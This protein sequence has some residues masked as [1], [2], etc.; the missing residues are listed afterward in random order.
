M[1]KG[2]RVREVWRGQTAI[3]AVTGEVD[4]LTAPSME[5]AVMDCL[6][7]TPAALIIDLLRTEFLSSAGIG[8]LIGAQKEADEAGIGFSVVADSPGTSRPLTL[9]N[10]DEILNLQP[11]VDDARESLLPK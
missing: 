10:M 5:A 1:A 3:V 7:K 6:A 4:M 8:V 2:L 9:M 11:T